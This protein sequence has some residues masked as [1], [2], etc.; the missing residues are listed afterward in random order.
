MIEIMHCATCLV[1]S[2]SQSNGIL[3]WNILCHEYG[4]ESLSKLQSPILQSVLPPPFFSTSHYHTATEIC[5]NKDKFTIS[6]DSYV[7]MV[8]AFSNYAFSSAAV[9]GS[10]TR[11]FWALAYLNENIKA[12]TMHQGGNSTVFW[13]FLASFLRS[14]ECI[15]YH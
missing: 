2:L 9:H 14:S 8:R 10:N 4:S 13:F 12:Y 3:P 15:I 5:H 7:A 6:G 11:M 1:V